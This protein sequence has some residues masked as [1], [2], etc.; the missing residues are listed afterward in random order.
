MAKTTANSKGQIANSSPEPKNIRSTPPAKTMAELMMSASTQSQIVSLHKGQLVEGVVTKLTPSEIFVDVKAKTHAM[1]LEKDRRIFRAL[2]AHLKVG[3]TVTVSVL[4]PESEFG[5]PVVSLRRFLDDLQ[6]KS[7]QQHKDD[8][9]KLSATINSRTTG[10][11]LVTTEDGISGFLPNSQS[12]FSESD[13]TGKK[14]DLYILELQKDTK[15]V[16]FSQ[17]PVM[18][19]DEF[20]KAISSFKIGQTISATI[21]SVTSFGVF[22]MISAGDI[23]LD[24][25][26]HISELS[27]DR[28]EDAISKFTS[29][30][31]VQAQ[32]IGFDKDAKRID[33]SVKRLTQ[34]PF[35]EIMKQYVVDQKVTGTVLKILSNGLV[36]ELEKGVEGFIRKEKIPPTVSYKEGEEI[37]AVVAEVDSKKHRVVLVPILKEKPI[38]YR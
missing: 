22:V 25:L 35:K 19:K 33:L 31:S 26:I 29:G 30:Q 5:Y 7:L 2:M 13:P 16:I 27:W 11:Y 21:S 32:I 20:E 3:D 34:D 17:K 6:W 4:S 12:T 15:K 18:D 36:I 28:A 38:G 8:K 14:T 10:G 1:V 9:T 24:G 37:Q 23:T